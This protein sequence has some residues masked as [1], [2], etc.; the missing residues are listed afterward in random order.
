MTMRCTWFLVIAVVLLSVSLRAQILVDDGAYD[1]DDPTEVAVHEAAARRADMLFRN[2]H[3][4]T[5]TLTVDRNT[6][7]FPEEA[8]KIEIRIANPTSSPLEIPDPNDPRLQCF[9]GHVEEWCR[10]PF[11]PPSTVIGPGQVIILTADSEDLGA[12]KHWG[13]IGAASWFHYLLGGSVDLEVGTP[14]L[15]ASA[16]VPLRVFKTYRETGMSKPKTIQEAV[17]LVAVQLNGEHVIM[18]AQHNVSSTYGLDRIKNGTLPYRDVSTGAPWVR[19]ATLPA[20]VTI[21]KAT[22]DDKD[23]LT[24]QYVSGGV[25]RTMHLDEKRHPTD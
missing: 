2:Y 15:E 6:P 23:R 10:V 17:L 22:A 21:L 16:V 1:P 12:A 7:Y 5:Y 25:A 8:I 19:L 3:K 4:L 20:A 18:A 13:L 24:V 9:T 14:I 11:N